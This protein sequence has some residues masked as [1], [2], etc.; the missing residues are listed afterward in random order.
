[1]TWRL[2]SII[3]VA[4][5]AAVLASQA[6][7]AATRTRLWNQMHN[8]AACRVVD[9]H[10]RFANDISAADQVGPRHASRVTYETLMSNR[11]ALIVNAGHQP[12]RI[13]WITAHGVVQH[14]GSFPHLRDV[15]EKLRRWCSL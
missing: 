15:A 5:L 1:M 11:A 8:Y 13:R 10:A 3:L 7:G 4:L 14:L 12:H 6:Q 2:G 9:P